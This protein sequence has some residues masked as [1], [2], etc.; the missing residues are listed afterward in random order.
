MYLGQR[1]PPFPSQRSAKPQMGK[2][3]PFLRQSLLPSISSPPSSEL[4]DN[5]SEGPSRETREQASFTK[6]RLGRT[7]VMRPVQNVRRRERP[8]FVLVTRTVAPG[9]PVLR[10]LCASGTPTWASF[11]PPGAPF[12]LA[13]PATRVVASAPLRRVRRSKRWGGGHFFAAPARPEA[14][15]HDT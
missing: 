8:S 11:A 14:G 5:P 10:T 2:T 15:S 7:S 3:F 6:W 1:H 13:P 4:A 12:R 9:M